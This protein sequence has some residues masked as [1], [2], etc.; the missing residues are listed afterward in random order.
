[1]SRPVSPDIQASTLVFAIAD[2]VA[3]H[4]QLERP[5]SPALC[6]EMH[7]GLV[8][9]AEHVMALEAVARSAGLFTEREMTAVVTSLSVGERRALARSALR[10][11]EGKIVP[12]SRATPGDVARRVAGRFVDVDGGAA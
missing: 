3:E 8:R 2:L 6:G 4:Q 10:R 12:L 11:A 5:I 1:M 9:I 7:E